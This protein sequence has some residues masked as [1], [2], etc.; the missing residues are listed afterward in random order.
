MSGI[1]T[2]LN[3]HRT[4][5]D[6]LVMLCGALVVF[7]P[8]LTGDTHGAPVWLNAVTIGLLILGIGFLEYSVLQRWEEVALALIGVWLIIA[9]FV[10]G[11][12]DAG[13]LRLWHSGLGGLAIV[14]AVLQLWQDWD[15][16]DKELLQRERS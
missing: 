12:A 5:E 7:S 16:T 3:T 2:H 4:W 10:F 6:W 8:G 9:P 14:L 11:Y 1:D 15:L 13:Q